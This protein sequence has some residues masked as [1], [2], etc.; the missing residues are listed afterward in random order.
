MKE[1][2]EHYYLR[3]IKDE[4]GAFERAR[5]NSED[6]G[7]QQ[8][9]T[10]AREWFAASAKLLKEYSRSHA[11]PEQGGALQP[12]PG[13]AILRLANLAEALAAGR[14]PQ[15]VADIA[16]AG[17]RPERWP[18]ERRD[19]ATALQYIEL[20]KAGTIVDKRFIVTVCDA[21]SVDRTTVRDWQKR[22]EEILRDLPLKLPELFPEAL[23]IAGARYHF[24]RTGERTEEVE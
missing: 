6:A 24:N 13:D 17:G 23:L 22:G 9:E 3:L 19:I 15:A 4:A 8:R 10:L 16:A 2:R 7:P 5:R 12:Y 11:L 20:A 18:G 21:F 1:S 14:V